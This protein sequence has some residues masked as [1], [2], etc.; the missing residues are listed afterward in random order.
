MCGR[1]VLTRSASEIA[2]TFEAEVGADETATGPRFNVA[3]A[4]SILAIRE[5]EE[6][7]RE[8]VEL[9]WGLVPFWVKERAGFRSSINAR[10]ETVATKP[11]FRA[12][13][14]RRRCLVPADGFYEWE[15]RGKTKKTEQAGAPGPYFFSARDRSLLAMAGIWESWVDRASGEVVE[16]CALLTVAANRFMGRIHHRMPALIEKARARP[17]APLRGVGP[18]QLQRL[19]RRGRG[20]SHELDVEVV[21]PRGARVVFGRSR[22]EPVALG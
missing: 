20:A 18:P 1:M 9:E 10:S 16:S 11:S 12:A 15:R 3:P 5:D 4:Q 6:G 17:V 13:F 8:L 22:D 2:E 21:G 19:G 14:Q 7:S